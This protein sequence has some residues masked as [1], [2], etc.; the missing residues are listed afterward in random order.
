MGYGSFHFVSNVIDRLNSIY[1]VFVHF[2]SQHV[3]GI[4]V[5]EEDRKHTW[6][7]DADAVSCDFEFQKLILVYLFI[8]ILKSY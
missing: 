1:I 6:M 5:E 3:I 7:E 2:L 4:G 8:R